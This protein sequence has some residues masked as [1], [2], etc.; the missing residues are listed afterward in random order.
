MSQFQLSHYLSGITSCFAFNRGNED[1]ELPV[2]CSQ[3]KGEGCECEG[4]RHC[5]G[6]T[7][8]SGAGVD[9]QGLAINPSRIH[10]KSE[11]KLCW[12]I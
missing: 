3:W 12:L 10:D 11:C 6:R 7:G 1:A 9:M 2:S 8:V 5:G 4:R